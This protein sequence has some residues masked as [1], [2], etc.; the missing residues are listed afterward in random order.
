MNSKREATKSKAIDLNQLPPWLEGLEPELFK[1]VR[2]GNWNP[3][4][5]RSLAA[6]W[7]RW[8]AQLIVAADVFDLHNDD[9]AFDLEQRK[10]KA[11]DPAFN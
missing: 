4:K 8:A 6:V 9:A 1:L 10:L 2:D 7:A 5:C 3:A 11:G